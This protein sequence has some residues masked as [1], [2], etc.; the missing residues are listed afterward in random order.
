MSK[1]SY[2]VKAE[3]IIIFSGTLEELSSKL[4][5]ALNIPA[6]WYDNND[7]PPY[8]KYALCD[9][10]GFFIN[11]YQEDNGHDEYIFHIATSDILNE[12]LYGRMHDFSVWLANYIM[13]A[14]KLE[15]KV[16]PQCLA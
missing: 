13:F 4:S 6:F 12:S 9:F 8:I 14:C 7:E 15:T 16:K 5:T 11:L 1:D 2:G 3:C 10:F